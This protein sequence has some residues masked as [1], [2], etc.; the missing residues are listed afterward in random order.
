MTQMKFLIAA[1]AASA[2]LPAA[3]SVTV[4]GSSSARSCYEAAESE[5]RPGRAAIETC[6]AAL[7][8]EPLTAYEI[9]ATHVNRGILRLRGG[10]VEGAIADFDAA[11]ARD[12][13]EPEAY[14]N[15]GVALMQAPGRAQAAV[16]LFSMAIEKKT[17]RPAI[18][19]LGRG[20]AHE[21]LG[22]V[23]SAYHDYRKASAADPE[24]D[25][26]RLE[27]ARFRVTRR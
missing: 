22:D 19:F 7:R 14:V 17:R 20:M 2:A 3:A 8:Q 1:A 23:R 4:V 21:E 24:W 18:A 25:L 16:S 6:D 26:P 11:A 27:L 13:D 5:M 10:D 9:V 12:P 15:K